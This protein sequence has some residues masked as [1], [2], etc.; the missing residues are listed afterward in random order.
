[1]HHVCFKIL[2][3]TA[4]YLEL[5]FTIAKAPD[6]NDIIDTM[7]DDGIVA[8]DLDYADYLFQNFDV[9]KGCGLKGLDYGL[10]LKGV[11]T[12]TFFDLRDVDVIFP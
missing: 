3:K 9:E 12:N 1:M 4:D 10:D 8:V 5:P 6:E 11:W 2:N 7:P